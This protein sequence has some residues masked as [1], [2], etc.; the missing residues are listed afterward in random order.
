M[1]DKH[2]PGEWSEYHRVLALA[3][4]QAGTG[5][6]LDI[7]YRLGYWEAVQDHT[8]ALQR[9]NVAEEETRAIK[10]MVVATIGGTVEDR[11][12]NALNYLQRLRKLVAYE[13]ERA[14]LIRKGQDLAVAYGK[15]LIDL[16]AKETALKVAERCVEEN[17]ELRA[18]RDRFRAE[19]W[20][21]TRRGALAAHSEP[22]TDGE[23]K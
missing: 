3:R 15:C 11:P 2:T 17:E 5:S 16:H 19:L 20:E 22:A 4:S 6:A 10:S 14:E 21:F 9:A 13:A 7:L 23:G 8:L 12:T 18:E 1:S